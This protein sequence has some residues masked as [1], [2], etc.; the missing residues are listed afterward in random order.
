MRF[1]DILRLCRQN[2]LRRKS[3]TVL[4]VLGVVV[5]C[6]SIVLMVSLGAGINEQNERMLESMG[7]LSIITVYAGGS[8]AGGGIDG[9]QTALDD[10]AV[11]EFRSIP[12]VAGVTPMASMP[13]TTSLKTGGGDRY[14]VDYVQVM[15][16]DTTQL[17]AM[18][19]VLLEGRAPLRS[20]E[21]LLGE[22]TAYDFMDRFRAGEDSMRHHSR[23]SGGMCVFDESTGTCR[24]AADDP[25]P[26]F[27][28]LT[29]PLTLVAGPSFNGLL[30]SEGVMAGD[31][32]AAGTPL[33]TALTPVG[34][35]K[36]DYN[37]GGATSSGLILPLDDLK[38]LVRDADPSSARASAYDQA[39]IKVTD[40]A[41]VGEVED[42]IRA[43]GFGTSSVRQMRESLEEQSRSIQLILGGIG[44]VSLL[45]AAIG[46]ANTMIMSVTERTRE[47]GIMK[48]LGCT[49]RDIRIMFLGEAGAIGF[50]GG[51][52]GCAISAIASVA[53]NLVSF[54]SADVRG[55]VTAVIGGGEATRVSVIPWW[56]YLFAIAFSTAIGLLSGF[57]PAN[58]AVR[59]PA[60][61]AIRN[62]T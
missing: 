46:I 13:Y 29:T 35:L 32:G 43:L 24:E 57:Q 10:K 8:G 44:A 14:V 26:F 61:D 45:V 62:A 17:D 20:G 53:I 58:R 42:Q 28:P 30:S 19:Y 1:A 18:G 39:L 12:Q 54:A 7:D 3:R 38:Q 6:C 60:L 59:I 2:L 37:K 27:D 41:Q 21:V 51:V 48:S 34:I 40:M 33:E 49:V 15:G 4:T 23:G 31:A 36:E 11:E 55:V 50:L 47:I 56:L 22:Y 5:G 25:D 52:I 16:I 9:K